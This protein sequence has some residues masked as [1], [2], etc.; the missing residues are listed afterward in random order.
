MK[1]ELTVPLVQL[2]PWRAPA[3]CEPPEALRPLVA[4][5]R[6]HDPAPASLQSSPSV[7]LLGNRAVSL[8][9]DEQALVAVSAPWACAAR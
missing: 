8:T 6:F 5:G 1:S 4:G 7:Q 2:V 9:V 3:E